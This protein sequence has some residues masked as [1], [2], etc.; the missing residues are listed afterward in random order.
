[1]RFESL[2]V[3]T[4]RPYLFAVR[5]VYVCMCGVETPYPMSTASALKL[6]ACTVPQYKEVR[7]RRGGIVSI[8][9]IQELKLPG[10]ACPDRLIS[11]HQLELR[12]LVILYSIMTWIMI[13]NP[14]FKV[15][16]KC[17]VRILLLL[18]PN[19]PL[20]ETPWGHFSSL[21]TCSGDRP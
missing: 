17:N 19:A 2:S 5:C 6:P 4:H 21:D 3:G 8:E 12:E 18:E 20:D 10:R 1:M 11:F 14:F 15:R 9:F 7:E 13:S 16:K